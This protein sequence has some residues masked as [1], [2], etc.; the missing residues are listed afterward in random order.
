[1]TIIDRL[2]KIHQKLLCD[3]LLP[4]PTPLDCSSSTQKL[5]LLTDHNLFRIY[6]L[7]QPCF[8]YP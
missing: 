6:L 7:G 5:A 3:Y 8:Y 4:E 1:M 2:D